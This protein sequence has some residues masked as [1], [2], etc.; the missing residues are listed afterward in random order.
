MRI[1]ICGTGDISHDFVTNLLKVNRDEISSV[2]QRNKQKAK[3]FAEQYEIDHH[4]DDYHEFLEHSDIVYI[5][6][7]NSLHYEFAKKALLKGKHVLMEKPF[8]SNLKEFDEL[9]ELSKTHNVKIIEV[10]RV[11]ALPNYKAIEKEIEDNKKEL[12]INISFCKQSRKYFD[13]IDGKDPNVFT[14][15]YS[16]GALYDLGVYGIHFVVGLLGVPEKTSYHAY[17]L[18]SG[19]DA[20]GSLILEYPS[21]IAEIS[22][23]KITHGNSNFVIQG[24]DKKIEGQSA[25]SL[26][27]SFNVTQDGQTETI[28][29]QDKPQMTYFIEEA[30][31]LIHHNQTPRY[32]AL[33]EQSRDVMKILEEARRQTDI[34]FSADQ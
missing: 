17:K 6:L 19:V 20:F 31:E 3:D 23:S 16:G 5:G 7:P 29:H 15:E 30:L 28:N 27:E 24:V 22:V 25:V 21:A 18:S 32:E 33:L 4:T 9:V 14:T 10:S 11:L 13:F 8:C 12:F 2:Q 1:G 26:I 34:V